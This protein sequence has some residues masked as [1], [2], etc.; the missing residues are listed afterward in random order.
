MLQFP[1]LLEDAA[2][3]VASEVTGQWW[4]APGAKRL[5]FAGG[6]GGA[7]KEEELWL[8]PGPGSHLPE[9]LTFEQ[10]EQSAGRQLGS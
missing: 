6:W 1:D 2:T 3:V 9:F 5:M 10:R 8:W 4:V 7:F